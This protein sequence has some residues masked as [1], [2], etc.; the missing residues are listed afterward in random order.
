MSDHLEG[1]CHCGAVRVSVPAD[2]FGVVACHCG[3]CQK[4]RPRRTL[5]D[6]RAG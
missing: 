4:L 6:E 5:H 2:A 1:N 3:D